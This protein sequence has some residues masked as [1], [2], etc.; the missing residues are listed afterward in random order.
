MSGMRHTDPR[1][2][3][4]DS[5][6]APLQ[7]LAVA[8]T[9]ALNALDGFDVLA[10]SF[11]S[12]GI[13]TEWAIDR[14][15]LGV[16]LSMELLGMAL[17]SLVIGSVADRFGRRPTIM[18]CLLLMTVGML[19]ATTSRSV[20][21]LSVWRVVTGLGI[22]GVLASI[23]AMA[24]EF[25]SAKRRALAVSLMSI[26]YPIGAVLGGLVAAQLLASGSWRSVF[27][28][29][30]T[31]TAAMIPAVALW[32]PESVPW[33]VRTQPVGALTAINRTL[34]R[35]GH[36]EVAALPPRATDPAPAPVAA[37]FTPALARTTTLVTVAYFCHITT[38]YFLLKWVPKIVADMG[39][40]PS[41]AA[42]VLVWANVGGASGGALLGLATR[43]VS[44]TRL[45][46]V[47]MFASTAAVAWFGQT[48]ANLADLSLAC[49]V[50]GFCLNAG[51]V[52]IYAV[53]A[54]TFPTELRAS[55]T[56]FAIGVGRGGSTLAPIIAGVLFAAGATLGRVS[57][58]MAL[59]SLLGAC[60]L[61]WLTMGR[62]ASG[63]L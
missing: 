61:V 11:A 17:G 42:G 19:A 43:F 12:P 54:Q 20:T 4:A 2:T 57:L 24:A 39:F 30:A 47:A 36:A 23:T 32:L 18:G 6:M 15:A 49:A 8:I 7:V 44:V 63:S 35:F 45:T 21:Q 1:Q 29:G 5:P 38:F 10:I 31:M 3:L 9:V 13:A 28:F 58:A 25:A 62:R 56:G 55:G 40:A 60:T 51:I 26:G 16:V 53:F 14:A 52:G 37:L 34:R 41:A 59:G 33:L 48:A 50:A 46:I 22:G 27:Y